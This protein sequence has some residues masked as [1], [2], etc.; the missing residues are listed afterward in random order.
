MRKRQS[1]VG[2]RQES[3]VRIIIGEVRRLHDRRE[4]INKKNFIWEWTEVHEKAFRAA[5]AALSTVQSLTFYDPKRPTA[6]HVDA[7]RLH[8]LGFVLKQQQPDGSWQMVQAG[9]RFLSDAEKT[10]RDD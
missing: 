6:L 3:P 8:G 9:S 7:S 1:S 10:L 5:R 4:R 2:K